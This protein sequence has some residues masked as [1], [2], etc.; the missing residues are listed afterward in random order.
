[1]ESVTV[2]LR[3]ALFSF[4]GADSHVP[5]GV[6]ILDGRIVD[7]PAGALTIEV[8]RCRDERGREISEQSLTL[9]LPWAKIDHILAR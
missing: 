8:D 9:Q 6:M 1:M 4:G 5:V 7:R 3:T 2:F